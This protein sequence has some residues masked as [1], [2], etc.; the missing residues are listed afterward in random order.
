[1]QDALDLGADSIAMHRMRA[2]L[3]FFLALL[4]SQVLACE[5][6]DEGNMPLRRALARVQMLPETERWDRAQREAGALVKYE[7]SLE[8]T[9]VKDRACFWTV[10]AMA[11]GVVWRRFYVTPDGKSVRRE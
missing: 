1:M 6:P 5:Y 7:L 10:R 9:M 11:N 4:S 8:E 2:L 3:L